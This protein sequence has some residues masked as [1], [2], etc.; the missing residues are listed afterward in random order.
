M[1]INLSLNIN[2]CLFLFRSCKLDVGDCIKRS[3]E[4]FNTWMVETEPDHINPLV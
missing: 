2:S 1:T 4:Y 3:V